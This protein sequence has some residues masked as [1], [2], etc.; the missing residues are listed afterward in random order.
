MKDRAASLFPLAMLV[1]LAA[2]TFWL[3][4]V[5]QGDSPRGPLRHDPDYWVERFEVRRFDPEG[6][7]QHT[8]VADKLLHYADDDTTVVTTPHITYHQQPPSEITARMAYVG[9]DGKEVDLVDDVRVIRHGAA[10]D[11][12]PTVI[13]TRTLKVF[14]DDE[15]GRSSDPVVI[16]R[17]R[18]FMKGSGLDID[19]RSGITVLRGRVTGTLHR[20]RTETP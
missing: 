5:I 3:N 12:P 17:G 16:T 4:R 18:S 13:E 10:G 7:L 6:K 20:N 11:S 8:L 1:L 9:Q 2:L 15:K 14:P 19:N